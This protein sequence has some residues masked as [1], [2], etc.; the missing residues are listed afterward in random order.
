MNVT[1]LLE[2]LLKADTEA[3]VEE[4]LRR[5]GAL[6]NPSLW[7]P[8]GDNENNFSIVGNQQES[9]A[10]ALVEKLINSIDHVLIG[11]CRRAGID[12]ESPEAPRAMAE[13]AERFF[14]IPQGILERL[15]PE[16]RA[17]LSE[18][19]WLV[20]TGDKDAPC[21]SVIDRGEGQ[22][23][24]AMPSTLLS[25]SRT[26][27]MKIPFVQGKFNMGGSGALPFCGR[28]NYQ[29]VLTRRDPALRGLHP[30]DPTVDLWGFTVVRRE[31][32]AP[33]R[34][35]SMYTYLAPGGEVL[36]LQADRLPLLPGPYPEAMVEPMEHG[37]FIKLY[38]YR[39]DRKALATNSIL[40]LNFEL[41][42]RLQEMK[43][44]VRICERRPGYHGHSFEATLSGMSVRVEENRE[45]LLEDG[46]ET[47]GILDVPGVGKIPLRIVAFKREARK[48]GRWTTP[49][50]AVFLTV[51]GQ[52][53]GT[54]S[55]SFFERSSLA[56]DYV[57]RDLMVV[58]DCTDIRGRVREDLFLNSRDRVRRTREKTAIEEALILALREH[59]GLRQLN[60]RRAEEE[61]K[62]KLKD[63]RPFADILSTLVKAS[64]SLAA[65]FSAG[66]L[67]ANPRKAG[68]VVKEWD[69]LRFPTFFRIADEPAEGL[70]RACPLNAVCGVPFETDAANDYFTRKD[71][72]GTL[73]VA[74]A[75][76]RAT[77][78]LCNGRASVFL[79]PPE[80]ARAGETVGIEVR[81][82]DPSRTEPFSSRLRVL[83]EPAA[84]REKRHH[85][86]EKEEQGLALPRIIPVVRAEWDP[87]GFD[88][89]S[90][91]VLR[92]SPGGKGFDA[93]VN[94]D[95]QW[96]AREIL[97]ARGAEAALARERF[98][99]GLVLTAMA[100]L[101]D[102]REQKA[103]APKE[104]PIED[105]SERIRKI[106]EASRGI[107]MVILP[108]ISS[109]GRLQ[110]PQEGES[111]AA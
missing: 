97:K 69:G 36:T 57:A 103:R 110:G 22:T 74:P 49:S 72:P 37:T 68:T 15:S 79:R 63:D 9:A 76:W 24:R 66:T 109:L 99:Y 45:R 101:H 8:L 4:A 100:M 70:L 17:R 3:R 58:L 87:Y 53:H 55:S 78:L 75:G 21:Y 47:G 102:Y 43:L 1:A 88:A 82:T 30:E 5:A 95:N 10:G 34:R 16:V 93:F 51:N 96:L 67:L 2:A 14:G 11:A 50:E 61:I 18:L 60:L 46:I 62:D 108:A 13:A 23:P 94:V 56:L 86:R 92:N 19:I 89:G 111:N 28:G 107:A 90:G 59:K 35:S 73:E 54:L 40:D 84:T 65:L 81:V 31:D 32:P 83:V 29:L 106:G 33:G 91:L 39:L 80:G 77:V 38:E 7:R 98:K 41:S 6:G 25:L 64:P 12:P 20:A 44:P 27:K 104:A 105:E 48:D 42:R 85:E 71:G 52:T 26:N